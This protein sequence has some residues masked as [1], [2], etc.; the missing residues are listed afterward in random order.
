MCEETRG[1]KNEEGI[2]YYINKTT[3]FELNLFSHRQMA[4]LILGCIPSDDVSYR[5]NKRTINVKCKIF[6]I[7]LLKI[8]KFPK[9]AVLVF[10]P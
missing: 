5:N 6:T 8:I 2:I 3:R 4:L 7:V 10:Q 1:K 9:C